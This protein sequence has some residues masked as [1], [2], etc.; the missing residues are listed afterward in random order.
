VYPPLMRRY[1]LWLVA[2]LSAGVILR[3]GVAWRMSPSYD[4]QGFLQAARGLQH[5]G[6]HFYSHN[7]SIASAEYPYP[8]AYLPW[9]LLANAIDGG[10]VQFWHIARLPPIVAD[11]AL[12][13]TV[14]WYLRGRGVSPLVCLTAAAAV[15]LGPTFLVTSSIEG[16]IDSVAI[17]PAVV[18]AILWERQN[19]P[20]RAVWAGLLIGLGAAVKT[21]PALVVLALLPTA[22]S[23]RERA[24]LVA[25]AA[26]VPA[27]M[28]LPF[29]VADPEGMLSLAYVG[30]PGAGGIAT[31]VQPDLI[32]HYLGDHDISSAYNNVQRVG[33]L[34][35]ATGALVAAALVWRARMTA[36]SA[37]AC[38]W[39]A[40]FATSVNYYQQ[41]LAWG[42]P[43][44]LMSGWV[45]PVLAAD[46]L[47]VVPTA[48]LYSQLFRRGPLGRVSPEVAAVPYFACMTMLWLGAATG[49]AALAARSWKARSMAGVPGGKGAP[50]ACAFDCN[51]DGNG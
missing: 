15:V 10:A 28:L 22:R 16:Q 30:Y 41:Y 12:A 38:I 49:A 3:V 27:S 40:V 34:L 35:T 1:R 23:H 45:L 44:F 6:L 26:A 9:F 7:N 8:P 17:L 29:A 43:F 32:V 36:I 48:L 13:W 39:L 33:W 42:W 24:V 4:L 19:T 11:I 31:I 51:D 18:A 5:W 2:L 20:H 25:F 37:A 21:A 46:L 14:Q 50:L 47:L